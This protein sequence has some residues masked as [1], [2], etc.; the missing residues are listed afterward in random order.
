VIAGDNDLIWG[1]DGDWQHA[2]RAVV[3]RWLGTPRR[4]GG[5]LFTPP[6]DFWYVIIARSPFGRFERYE[7]AYQ[8]HWSAEQILGYL[9]S[10]SYCSR[11]LLADR[12]PAF[13]R[14]L[15]ATLTTLNPADR[16]DAV[17][18]EAFFAWRR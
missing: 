13:E 14:D 4:A 12:A 11:Q 9:Y 17:T 3:Q 8:R 2:V 5:A 7:L 6:A 10:T 16:F 18:L 15:R 1:G